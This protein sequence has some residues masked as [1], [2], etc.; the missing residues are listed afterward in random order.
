[1][2]QKLGSGA[3]ILARLSRFDVL[4]MSSALPGTD[5]PPWRF[6][7]TPARRGEVPALGDRGLAISQNGPSQEYRT[8]QQAFYSL[9]QIAAPLTS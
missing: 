5:P 1:M 8:A 6:G 2:S 3:A 7:W 9:P 4:D